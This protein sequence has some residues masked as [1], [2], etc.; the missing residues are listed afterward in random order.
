MGFRKHTLI[1]QSFTALHT[2]DLIVYVHNTSPLG[3]TDRKNL[4]TNHCQDEHISHTKLQL[5]EVD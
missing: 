1:M 2:T 5:S 3:T 4:L